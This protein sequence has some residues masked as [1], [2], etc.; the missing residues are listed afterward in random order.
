VNEIGSVIPAKFKVVDQ[1]KG[2]STRDLKILLVE[3]NLINEK[4]ATT[5]LNRL[6]YSIDV[7]RTGKDALSKYRRGK[8]DLVLMDLKM[9]EMDGFQVCEAM[10]S[11][12]LEL[13][14]T[15]PP[16]IVALTAEDYMGIREKCRKAGMNGMLR[17]PFNYDELSNILDL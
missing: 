6:G 15:E 11:M 14:K 8:Y 1:N 13:E 5:S 3:D 2:R 4:I 17:K 9:P 7:S 12:D 10:R 16:K